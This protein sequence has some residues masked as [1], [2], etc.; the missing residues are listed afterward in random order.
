[1][2]RP[3][4]SASGPKPAT[5]T[6]K[7]VGERSVH[8]ST[9]E[10]DDLALQDLVDALTGAS[11]NLNSKLF[12][13]GR[14]KVFYQEQS[15]EVIRTVNNGNCVS[16]NSQELALVTASQK[17]RGR[18]ADINAITLSTYRNYVGNVIT[19]QGYVYNVLT[20]RRG[21]DYAVM[22]ENKTWKYGFKMVAFRGSIDR[23]GGESFFLGLAGKVIKVRGLLNQHETF[24]Y[25]IIVSDRAMILDVQ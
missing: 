24:G 7:N 9:I 16:C 14:C 5:V 4:S 20:S 23:I 13:C 12:Q 15:Y 17:R 22:F 2:Y 11:L 25:Q 21:N 8:S 19:F 18:N 3:S 6:F 10:V 1:V